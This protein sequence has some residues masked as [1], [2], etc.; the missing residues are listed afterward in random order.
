MRIYYV[1]F[2]DTD[3]VPIHVAEIINEMQ[4]RG[5]EVHIFTSIKDK[6]REKNL[7]SGGIIIHNL[8]AIRARFI[9]ELVFMVL[10]LPYL[11]VRSLTKKPDFFYTRHSASSF[12]VA[13]IARL[14][15][16]PCLV[17]IND[18]VLDKLKFTQVSRLK[19]KWIQLYHYVNVHLAHCLMPVTKQIGLWLS[20]EYGIHEKKVVVIPNGVNV[21][22]FSP[23]PR[24]EARERYG[25]PLDAKVV[26]SLGSLFPWAGIEILIA[27]ASKVLE[28][29]PET[30]FVIGS[31]EEPFVSR[32][33]ENVNRFG[34]EEKFLFFGFIP[35]DEASW[36]ISTSDICVAPFVFKETRTGISS[37]R[38]FSYLSCARSV[39]G[40]D[41]P[42]LGDM[43]ENEGM[44][45]SF[46]MGNQKALANAI[47]ELLSDI[48]KLR[49][50]A[51][52]ARSYTIKNHS[53]QSIVDRIETA[54]I[55]LK[56]RGLN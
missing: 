14:L 46:Q 18:I 27:S 16:I 34:L 2:H 28:K 50:M 44:G 22:R 24:P 10:L 8:W 31:G 56:R 7:S 33:K 3:Y 9:S 30:L 51:E 21:Y 43:L 13:L 45:V 42:G 48:N 41:I 36:F 5:R 20:H 12:I 53:W 19:L 49:D 52:K 15:G 35:W 11:F 4:R 29:Y 39:V 37:L 17:E 23:K 6:S 26:L 55:A 47:I 25:I 1:Y 40:S 32:L 38:V 54:S